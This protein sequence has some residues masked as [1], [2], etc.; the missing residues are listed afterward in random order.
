MSIKVL[1][2]DQLPLI[3]D[4]L[5]TA[6]DACPD[7][8]VV[9]TTDS[10]LQ[11]VILSRTHHPDVVLIGLSEPAPDLDLIRR[12]CSQEHPD[13]RLPR[14]VV[15]QFE[16]SD[17]EVA[18]LLA[19]GAKG[20]ISR[21]STSEEVIVATR[22]AA[23][24]RTVLGP[25]IV[26]RL[27][28]WFRDRGTASPAGDRPEAAALTRREREVLQLIGRGMS[29]EDAAAK[30]FIGVSTVRTHLHRIRHKVALKDRAQLV[31]FAYQAGLMREAI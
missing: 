6:L 13:R 28:G 7:I 8:D 2:C 22:S 1:I 16:Y 17:A 19:V 4:G 15:F 3:R 29:I 10:A 14:V 24:G 18:D 21:D 25:D 5:R 12:L 20:L 31:A 26:E 9:A 23:R 30:L 11:T 27:V